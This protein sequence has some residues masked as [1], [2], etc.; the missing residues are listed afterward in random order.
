MIY[1]TYDII[2]DPVDGWVQV[3]RYRAIVTAI[4]EGCCTKAMLDSS[5]LKDTKLLK[6]PCAH[7][8]GKVPIGGLDG[9]TSSIFYFGFKPF[10]FKSF[11]GAEHCKSRRTPGLQCWDQRCLL[12]DAEWLLRNLSPL[13]RI[14]VVGC[15][16]CVQYPSYQWAVISQSLCDG[17]REGNRSF[18]SKKG[19]NIGSHWDRLRQQQNIMLLWRGLSIIMEMIHNQRR[20]IRWY[21]DV[22]L[23]EK[24][25]DRGWR[26]RIAA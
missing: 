26:K 2:L 5:D 18:P 11:Y 22:E 25:G 12:A 24:W 3:S 21:V 16:S 14:V 9:M 13:L 6:G 15:I 7:L 8:P 4:S 20:S 1:R 10:V 23:E 19:S 17:P